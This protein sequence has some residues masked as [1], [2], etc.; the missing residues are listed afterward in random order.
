MDRF[1]WKCHV[2]CSTGYCLDKYQT[3]IDVR[4]INSQI[5]EQANAG[6]KHLQAQLAYMSPDNFM[7]HLSLFLAQKNMKIRSSQCNDIS[8]ILGGIQTLGLST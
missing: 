8:D 4:N 1:H 5:N 3:A 6:L 7:F 2:G